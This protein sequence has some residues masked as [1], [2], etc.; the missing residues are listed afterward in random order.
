MD[1]VYTQQNPL[2][3]PLRIKFCHRQNGFQ[4]KPCIFFVLR[5]ISVR[6][7][8]NFS[9]FQL[10]CEVG[11]SACLYFKIKQSWPHLLS[12][13][14]DFIHALQQQSSC[15]LFAVDCPFNVLFWNV[16]V[17]GIDELKFIQAVRCLSSLLKKLNKEKTII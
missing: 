3:T 7:N 2:T 11:S 1:S 17:F 15:P 10:L 8:K 13:C 9:C 16:Q 12:V 6:Q 5:Q 4:S 14:Q